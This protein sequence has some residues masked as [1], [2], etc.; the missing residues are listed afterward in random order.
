MSRDLKRQGRGAVRTSRQRDPAGEGCQ[1]GAGGQAL[2]LNGEG[3]GWQGTSQL[4]GGDEKNHASHHS[5][6]HMAQC[7]I[8][9]PIRWGW[10]KKDL[11]Y[12]IE[13]YILPQSQSPCFKWG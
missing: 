3:R 5:R 1:A 4:G 6:A 10:L 8:N 7:F 9:Y 13:N 11:L 12:S 2:E